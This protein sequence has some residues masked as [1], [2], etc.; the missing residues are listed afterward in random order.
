MCCG[1]ARTRSA[2]RARGPT[3]FVVHPLLLQAGRAAQ[4]GARR[5][6][7]TGV[8]GREVPQSLDAGAHASRAACT[9]AA[10]PADKGDAPHRFPL[11]QPHCGPLVTTR[12]HAGPRMTTCWCATP[13]ATSPGAHTATRPPHLHSPTTWTSTQTIQTRGSGASRE[14]RWLIPGSSG[15]ND[16]DDTTGSPTLR[17]LG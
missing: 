5:T 14:A 16:A 6:V 15:R 9:P 7:P 11:R 8:S 4:L 12:R 10:Q 3:V 2:A 17:S 13:M 1:R